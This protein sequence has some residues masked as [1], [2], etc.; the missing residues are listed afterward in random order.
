M[1]LEIMRCVAKRMTHDLLSLGRVLHLAV[2]SGN[3]AAKVLLQIET[4]SL[5]KK[6]ETITAEKEAEL[7][8][9]IKSRYDAQVSP[10]YAAARLWTDGCY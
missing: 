3:S 6:G 2:M 5:K 7:F 8:D 10:Y 9:E 4:A 1:A